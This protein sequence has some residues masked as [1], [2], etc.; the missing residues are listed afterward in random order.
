M[1]TPAPSPSRFR[2]TPLGWAAVLYVATAALLLWRIATEPPYPFNW[3]EYTAF[4]IFRVWEAGPFWTDILQPGNGVMTD[5]GRGLL[6]G[7]PAAA[8]FALFG[9]GLEA[10]RIPIALVAALAPPL[11]WLAGRRILPERV[12]LPGAWLLAV[13][14]VFLLYGRTATLVGVSLVPLLLAFLA[15]C[16]VLTAPPGM[17]L[18]PALALSGALMLGILSYAPVR[19]FW[20]ISVVVLLAASLL[21]RGR[22]GALAGA[23]LLAL[24]GVPLALVALDQITVADPSPL[25][26]ISGYFRARDETVFSMTD[27]D[28]EAFLREDAP[29]LGT[30]LTRLVLQNSGDLLKIVLDRGTAPLRSNYWNARG[31]IWPSWM[32][33][34]VLAG[35]ALAVVRAVRWRD[36]R[37]LLPLV[38]LAGF[39]APLL[40]TSRVDSGRVLAAVPFACLLAAIALD[41][42]ARKIAS[43]VARADPRSWVPRP[44]PGALAVAAVLA[45]LGASAEAGRQPP[46]VMRQV[47]EAL[48]LED[49]AMIAPPAGVVLVVSPGLG[50]EIERVHAASHRLLLDGTYRFID[51]GGPDALDRGPERPRLRYGEALA[52]LEDG[53]LPGNWCRM[54]FAVQPEVRE[55]TDAALAR[56][57]CRV[58]PQIVD[59]P[60]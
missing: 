50:P 7:F 29:T 37:A 47:R 12:A 34:L 26:A 8:G 46:M 11:L 38:C 60:Q 40:L 49:L 3:E 33:L 20:P 10:L 56:F 23:A 19:L 5:S 1:Y 6:T 27:R 48:A 30:P 43:A 31:S 35:A 55:R 15:L 52:W 44:L 28:H 9:V 42:G 18:R 58:A 21:D 54:L 39:A 51:L 32:G 59:L 57:R 36:W 17:L 16:A 24:A 4:N 22:R 2:M 53:T 41:A 13:C 14:P 25:A 45:L